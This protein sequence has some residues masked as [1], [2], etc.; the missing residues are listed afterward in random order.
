MITLGTGVGSGFSLAGQIWH[1][2]LGMGGEVGHSCIEPQGL[3]CACGT[4]GCLEMYASA[5][6]LLRLVQK[7]SESTKVSAALQELLEQPGGGSASQVGSLAASGDPV[8]KLAFEQFGFYLGL[9][10]ANIINTLDLPMILIGGGVADAWELFAQSMFETVRAHSQI[11]RIAGPKQTKVLERNRT[12][13]G[14]AKLGS[15][16]GL[17]G[18][19]LLPHLASSDRDGSTDPL[20]RSSIQAQSLTK[21]I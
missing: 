6:G 12:F 21:M 8:A 11:Y 14:P 16:A 20:F 2:I 17:L 1:G 4:R 3:L 13:I 18:G 5:A 9:G 15:A 10:V 7:A 19:G